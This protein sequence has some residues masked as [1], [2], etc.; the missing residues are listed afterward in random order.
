M[1]SRIREAADYILSRTN[2]IPE[3]G[4]V[5]DSAAL[6][7]EAE[8]LY[9]LP[10]TDI[11][12][13]PVPAS[14]GEQ[15]KLFLGLLNGVKVVMMQQSL[16]MEEGFSMQDIVF[17]VRV[18]GL[19]GIKKLLLTTSC[20][21]LNPDFK[22]GDLLIIDDHINLMDSNPLIGKNMDE[23][24]PRFPDMSAPYSAV[25]INR[26][27]SAAADS[28]VGCH[29]GVYTAISGSMD[30][31]RSQQDYLRFIGSD[32]IGTSIV[33]EVI[34]ARHMGLPVFAIA[35]INE[36]IRNKATQHKESEESRIVMSASAK[37]AINLLEQMV[38]D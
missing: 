13:F 32:C 5:S 14:A 1:L 30:A 2:F 28:S 21:S 19:L 33:P 31:A 18:M 20:N 37:Y 8:I 9:T 3:V 23:L 11:T 27:K 10:Y 12:N 29:V 16:K 17:P 34:A 36:V 24:G 22:V 6:L 7:P 38:T 15:G 4:I 25:M 26:A 35:V